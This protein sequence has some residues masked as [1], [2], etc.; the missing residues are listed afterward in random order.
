MDDR[1]HEKS[2]FCDTCRK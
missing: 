1:H 2:E